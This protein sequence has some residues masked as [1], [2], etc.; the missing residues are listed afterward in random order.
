LPASGYS[1]GVEHFL[2][3]H[4]GHALSLLPEELLIDLDVASP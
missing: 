3:L 4:C 2:V 1:K